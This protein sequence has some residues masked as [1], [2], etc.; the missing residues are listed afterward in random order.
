M[1]VKMELPERARSFIEAIAQEAGTLLR[2]RLSLCHTVEYKGEINLV[3]EADRMAEQLI[4]AR[5]LQAYP[6]HDIL[7]EESP[8]TAN[9]SGYR[10]IIDPLD[11]TTNYA[12][13]FPVFSVSIALEVEGAIQLGAV[14]H[15]MLN[16]LFTAERGKGAFLN[17]QRLSVSPTADLG[18]SLLA[19]GFPYD[20]RRD[21]NNNINYFEALALSSQAVRRAGSAALD[22]AYV[23]AGRFDGFWELK[24]MPWDT[25][26]GWLLVEEAG[27]RVTDLTGGPYHLR[28]PHLLASNGLIHE[29]MLRRLTATDPLYQGVL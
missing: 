1:V 15:P 20:L 9:G 24:L 8:A 22:L 2:S 17:G 28:S 5:I 16:E 6:G 10:W 11:G 29:A 3:T 12:H 13:G 25:A 27:G 23:A 18:R 26:A 19:T 21:R 7:A 14:Y 4:V